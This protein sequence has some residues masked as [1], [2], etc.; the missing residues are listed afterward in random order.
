M[1]P[2]KSPEREYLNRDLKQMVSILPKR[3]GSTSDLTVSTKNPKNSGLKG[4]KTTLLKGRSDVLEKFIEAS[5]ASE[6]DISE[7]PSRSGILTNALHYEVRLMRKYFNKLR[8]YI[9]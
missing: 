5:A 3:D 9:L 7:A 8:T 4:S 6:Y 1:T 2:S